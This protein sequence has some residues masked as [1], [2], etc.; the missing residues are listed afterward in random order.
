MKT[1]ILALSLLLGA[2]PLVA[3][4]Y[5]ED[6]DEDTVPPNNA[7][8]TPG[9][10]PLSV[11]SSL[12]TYTVEPLHRGRRP[13]PT[14]RPKGNARPTALP[15]DGE[16]SSGYGTGDQA[17]GDYPVNGIGADIGGDQPASSGY[18]QGNDNLLVGGWSSPGIQ[19]GGGYHQPTPAAGGYQAGWGDSAPATEATEIRDVSSTRIDSETSATE[20]V[21]FSAPTSQS[22]STGAAGGYASPT[23]EASV[24]DSGYATSAVTYSA[25]E[26]AKDYSS[27]LI[28]AKGPSTSQTAAVSD[29]AVT[30][31]YSVPTA[32]AYSSSPLEVPGGYAALSSEIIAGSASYTSPETATSAT[33]AVLGPS[34]SSVMAS[35]STASVTGAVNFSVPS[36]QA[37]AISSA[38][39]PATSTGTSFSVSTASQGRPTTS[40]VSVAVAQS[41]KTSASSG[42][43]VASESSVSAASSQY[44]SSGTALSQSTSSSTASSSVEAASGGG[45]PF[46]TLSVSAASNGTGNYIYQV[47]SAV[48]SA[49]YASTTDMTVINSLT[50]TRTV[51]LSSQSFFAAT[52]AATAAASAGYNFTTRRPHGKG[53]PKQICSCWNEY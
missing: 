29:T 2:A 5:G 9:V 8:N 17:S 46:A 50:M 39:Y 51:Y 52:A 53:G 4:Q 16:T 3:A 19:A 33:E 43:A 20:A 7:L 14:V 40:S 24:D 37:V 10:A 42:Y 11:A 13:W 12:R 1:G 35:S 15:Y 38:S 41:T 25:S 23:A 49:A 30:G 32:Q 48:S 34:S 18:G 26:A 44:T 27:S 22:L 36:V 47:A 45:S 21:A 28:E 6:C 31:A